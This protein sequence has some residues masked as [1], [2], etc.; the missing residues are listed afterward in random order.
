MPP[1][2]AVIS[3]YM[4]RAHRVAARDPV[5]LK[6]FFEVASLLAAPPVMLTPS[7]AWRV[8]SGGAGAGAAS[9]VQKVKVA[10]A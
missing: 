8:L 4:A 2:F 5:V 6:R 3:A 9:P 10:P 1:G 7:I